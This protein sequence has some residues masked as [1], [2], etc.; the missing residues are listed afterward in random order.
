MSGRE[1]SLN[2]FG[3]NFSEEP[4]DHVFGTRAGKFKSSAGDQE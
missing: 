4:S 2:F 3:C 1:M